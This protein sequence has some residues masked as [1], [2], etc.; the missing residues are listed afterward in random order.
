MRHEISTFVRSKYLNWSLQSDDGM[1]KVRQVYE[2]LRQEPPYD[3]EFFIKYIEIEKCA[4]KL[5]E[6]RIEKAF[7]DSLNHFDKENVDL[8]LSYIEFKY[9]LKSTNTQEI[10]NIYWRAL[11]SLDSS[12]VE[13]FTQKFCLFKINVSNSEQP[14]DVVMT[15]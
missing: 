1:K 9:N 11:K 10:S 14:N 7:E 2:S 6:K 5:D 4:S 15:E 12:L 13:S 8:W 3:V